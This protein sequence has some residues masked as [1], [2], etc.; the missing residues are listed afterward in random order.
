MSSTF[1]L[2]EPEGHAMFMHGPSFQKHKG[3]P[4]YE[5]TPGVLIE[6]FFYHGTIGIYQI[7]Q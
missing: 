5:K 7:S 1:L 3:K 4:L 2:G 6:S